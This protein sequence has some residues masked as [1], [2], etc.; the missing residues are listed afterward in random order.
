MRGDRGRV[1][2]ADCRS[3]IAVERVR[4]K[5][6]V[7]MS[8]ARRHNVITATAAATVDPVIRPRRVADPSVAL[9]KAARRL[10]DTRSELSTTASG[11]R[12]WRARNASE[13]LIRRAAQRDI[14]ARAAGSV[15]NYGGDGLRHHLGW[16]A[17]TTTCSKLS[18]GRGAVSDGGHAA[19]RPIQVRVFYSVAT[20]TR[21]KSL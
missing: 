4:C 18:I 21:E 13:T 11:S 10:G 8:T 12:G 5:A 6:T 9:S 20:R 1:Q 15:I 3:K 16:Q 2:G 14:P 17:S 7:V 19:A